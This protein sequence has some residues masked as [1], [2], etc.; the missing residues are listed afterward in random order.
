M[1]R[2]LHCAALLVL[3][4]EASCGGSKPSRGADQLIRVED[5]QLMGGRLTD[6]PVRSEIEVTAVGLEKGG[7]VMTYPGRKGMVFVGNAGPMAHAVA[8]AMQGEESYWILPVGDLAP[9]TPD[10]MKFQAN[11]SFSPLIDPEGL[12]LSDLTNSKA[13]TLEFRGIDGT[14]L[15]GPERSVD[16]E[17]PASDP[18]GDVVVSLRWNAPVDLDLHVLA[19]LSDGTGTTEIWAKAPGES[20]SNQDAGDGQARLDF[21]SNASCEIDNL[22]RENVIWSGSAPP[23]HYEVRVDAFSL[24]G[25]KSAYWE[26][27]ATRQGAVIGQASGVLTDAQASRNHVSGSGVLAFEF[28]IL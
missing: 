10:L 24:C 28:D 21:D 26:V 17:I 27:R 2:K 22:D 14:G 5:G 13:L 20:S 16:V 19:P 25:Q 9:G 3:L 23:G 12:P 18:E 4:T 11:M 6:V 15:M 8:I 7:L 1:S